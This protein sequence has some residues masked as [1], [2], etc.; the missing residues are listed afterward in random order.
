MIG[1]LVGV[2]LAVL[3]AID[4]MA[5]KSGNAIE[6]ATAVEYAIKHTRDMP[7]GYDTEQVTAIMA[8]MAYRESH[9][10]PN[11]VGPAT[12]RK[13]DCGSYGIFQIE[14]HPEWLGN[15]TQQAIWYLDLIKRSAKMCPAH[16]LAMV[17]SGSCKHYAKAD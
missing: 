14:H 4:P 10:N 1:H 15:S 2:F 7:D 11:A 13:G 8:V 17:T 6:V 12:C 3:A 5:P 9:L 16:I